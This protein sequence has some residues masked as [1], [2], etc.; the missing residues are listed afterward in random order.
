[1]IDRSE[2]QKLVA[3]AVAGGRLQRIPTGVRALRDR[4]PPAVS[5]PLVRPEA[6]FGGRQ[7]DRHPH[8]DELDRSR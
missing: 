7:V 4:P 1:M 3:Q 6:C 5:E 8:L 2:L